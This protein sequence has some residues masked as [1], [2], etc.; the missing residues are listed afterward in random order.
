MGSKRLMLNRSDEDGDG[1]D[2]DNRYRD[3][4]AAHAKAH[5]ALESAGDSLAD[6]RLRAAACKRLTK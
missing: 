3:F 6:C 4:V 5:E 2:E 1:F